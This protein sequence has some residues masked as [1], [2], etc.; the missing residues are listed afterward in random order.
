MIEMI[1]SL[2]F[3]LLFLSSFFFE[4]V[5]RAESEPSGLRFS[6]VRGRLGT[7]EAEAPQ[8]V[9]VRKGLAIRAKEAV[10][11]TVTNLARIGS[12]EVRGNYRL[13]RAH[14][15][16]L[17][18]LAGE[19]P[20]WAW[21]LTP[22]E[23]QQRLLQNSWI[24]SVQVQSTILPYSLKLQ[25][26]EAE[27]WMIAEYEKHSWLV[28]RSGALLQ[29]LSSLQGA[30]LILE[31]T[32]LPRLDGLDAQGEVDSYLASANARFIYAVKLIKLLLSAGEL[33][34]AVER[35]TLLPNGGMLLQP[36]AES[37]FPKVAVALNSFSEAERVHT[38]L[39][40]VLADLQKRGERAS[41][42]DLRFKHQ[43]VVE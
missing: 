36:A 43:A 10:E 40:L 37:G 12:V 5:A 8:I 26:V 3:C 42:I 41:R 19:R 22:R 18:G 13:Q 9:P 34:F 29:P 24:E 1:R 15:L 27:P 21:E 32:E 39:K 11:Q 30:D 38:N 25:I 6:V 23:I 4:P 20:L 16:E 31:T 17:A 14:V 28:S 7:T 33:P 2:G 35:Y